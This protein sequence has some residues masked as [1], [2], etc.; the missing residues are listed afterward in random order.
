MWMTT[1][2][3]SMHAVPDHTDMVGLKGVSDAARAATL[4]YNLAGAARLEA[5]QRMVLEFA[6]LEEDSEEGAEEDAV[7]GRKAKALVPPKPWVAV[8][9]AMKVL[10]LSVVR[11]ML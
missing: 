7:E 2:T 6:L 3:P 5:A 9:S 10:P 8:G 11:K 1:T 4:A